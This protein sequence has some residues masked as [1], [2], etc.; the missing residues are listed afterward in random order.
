MA[1][2]AENPRRNLR[3]LRKSPEGVEQLIEAWDDL[4]ALLTAPA[5]PSWGNEPLSRMTSLLGL[6]AEGLVG[7]RLGALSRA[8]CGDPTGLSEAE[9]TGLD[10]ETIPSW[11]RGLLI[12]RIDEE[13]AALEAH[14]ETLDHATIEADRAEAG[15][16][17]LFDPSRE[18]CLARRY[19]SEARRGFFKAIEQL[20]QAEAAVVEGPKP[21]EVRPENATGLGSSRETR[22]GVNRD[23]QPTDPRPTRPAVETRKNRSRA[24]KS[25]RH[26]RSDPCWSALRPFAARVS[27]KSRDRGARGFE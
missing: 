16:R 23:P 4:R 3:K 21:L 11:A 25:G 7:T 14:Y 15:V 1:S 24:P 2:L 26:R 22:G 6:R 19:E 9:R 18:A 20:R 13:I 12:E 27:S 8:A 10:L 5:G 17:A